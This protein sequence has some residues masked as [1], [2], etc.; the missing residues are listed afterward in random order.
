MMSMVKMVEIDGQQADFK[1]SAANS[2][3]YRLK[4]QR[5]IYKYLKAMEKIMNILI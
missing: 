1:T 2:K 5:D 4:F 3:I